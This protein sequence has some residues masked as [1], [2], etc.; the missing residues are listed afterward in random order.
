MWSTLNNVV[1]TIIYPLSR[2][3]DVPFTLVLADSSLTDG[4]YDL[5][6]ASRAGREGACGVL[7]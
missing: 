4:H 5:I 1:T 3:I 6:L 2:I 7:F